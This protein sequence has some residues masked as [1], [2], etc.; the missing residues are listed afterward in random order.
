MKKEWIE[1]E[2][3]ELNINESE[4]GQHDTH[5]EIDGWFEGS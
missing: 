3:K 5:K 1:P 2:L 4:T